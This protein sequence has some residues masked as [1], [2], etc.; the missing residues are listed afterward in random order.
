MRALKKSGTTSTA[1]LSRRIHLKKRLVTPTVPNNTNQFQPSYASVR[2]LPELP[3]FGVWARSSTRTNP[4]ELNCMHQLLIL[5]MGDSR[6]FNRSPKARK[7]RSSKAWNHRGPRWWPIHLV[8]FPYD[9]D[10]P[11]KGVN[12]KESPHKM[13]SNLLDQTTWNM[14]VEI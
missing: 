2:G 11:F 9:T 7:F 8:N 12:A 6:R 3:S 13:P 1:C 5:I 10:L 4:N 14:R